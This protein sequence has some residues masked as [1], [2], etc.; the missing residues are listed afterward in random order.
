M[1]VYRMRE[2]KSLQSEGFL[3][4]YDAEVYGEEPMVKVKESE[5]RITI[6][7][8]FPGFYVSD[9]SRDVE[10]E[11]L[12]FEQVNIAE[13][14][15][16]GESG[17]PLLPSF[18]RYA[19]IPFNCD[20]KITVEKGEP[21]PFDDIL[22]SP[23]QEKLTD[24]PKKEI[25]EYDKEF[26]TKDQFYPENVVEVQGPFEIDDYNALLLHVRPLQ[27]NPARKK[28]I[29]F[30]T[31]IVTIDVFPEKSDHIFRDP[32]LTREAYGNLFLNPERGINDRVTKRG[33]ATTSKAKGSEFLIIYYDTFEE[34]AQNLAKWKNKRGLHT[35]A[36]P[37]KT[38]G[39]TVD[40]IKA[41][42]R[43]KRKPSSSPLRY[44]LLMGDVDL[45]PSEKIVDSPSGR[46]I[47]D[48]YYSTHRDPF[49][50]DEYVLPWLS[51]GRI[52]VTTEKEVNTVVDKIISYE[53]DPPQDPDYYRRMAFAAYFQD[54][55]PKD[56]R[57]DRAY[58]KTLETIREYM[59]TLGFDVERVYVSSNPDVKEYIDGTPVPEDV[60]NAITDTDT[61]TD[62][63]KDAVSRGYMLMGHRDHGY[64]TGWVHPAFR[65]NHL[66]EITS[67]APTIFYSINCLTGRFD[68][69]RG[70]D[71]FAEKLLK[72]DGGAPS[73]IAATRPSHTWLNDDLMKALFD[74][75]WAGVLPTF[76]HSTAS[77]PVK[78]GRL[79]DILNYA[80]MY[81][82][83][84]MSGS[85]QYIKD[86][87]EIYHVIGDPTLELWKAEPVTMNMRVIKRRGYVD[88]LLASCPRGSVITIWSEDN[89]LKRIEPYSTHVQLSLRSTVLP[90]S[91][92]RVCFWA[93]GYR[94]QEVVVE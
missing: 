24:S 82:L 37:L 40:D 41:F 38:V 43:K 48:Y 61:A 64:Y 13:T 81:L 80:K 54:K 77:Y 16:L 6:S 23:A 25:F 73:L 31:I 12:S 3:T 94:F 30:G 27:Y 65:V 39:D 53:K 56:G 26:Y 74:A 4:A 63:L 19:Q 47:T 59:V 55:H 72:M 89:L 76:P 42:I 90:S 68:V 83:V 92:I 57:A 36:L 17:K 71:S 29:G 8:M 14:G 70:R 32:E 79:G 69:D 66:D 20:Y 49:T 33:G 2:F 67:K 18:G 87:M 78:Y 7:Y 1:E 10:G 50:P 60:K 84:T 62:T 85:R 46:N 15:F 52:P 45:I 88:I 22:V 44:V 35:E 93:P 75:L 11:T 5:E 28:L 91:E 21:V 34:A 58:M 86:H 51:I 9:D